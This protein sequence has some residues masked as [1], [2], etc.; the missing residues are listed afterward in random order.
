[1]AHILPD[2]R[3]PLRTL[4]VRD[5]QETP[6][7]APARSSVSTRTGLDGRP[8]YIHRLKDLNGRQSAE[9]RNPFA[10]FTIGGKDMASIVKAYNPPYADS[11]SVYDYIKNSLAAWVDEAVAIRKRY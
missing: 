4:A 9:G 7:R 6:T 11:K 2:T 10:A 5:T 3:S 1:V 8:S